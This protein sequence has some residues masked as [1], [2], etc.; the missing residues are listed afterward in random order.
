MSRY[1]WAAEEIATLLRLK[2]EG[3][4]N[5]EIGERLSVTD[6]AVK[7]KL[8][9]MRHAPPKPSDTFWTPERLSNLRVGVENR[10]S[11][12]DIAALLGCT[13]NA[14]RGK[15]ERLGLCVPSLR[16][17]RN[18]IAYQLPGRPPFDAR[19]MEVWDSNPMYAQCD[20]DVNLVELEY[21]SARDTAAKVL[22]DEPETETEAP[23][24]GVPIWALRANHCRAILNDTMDTEALRYC[25]GQTVKGGPWCKTHHARYCTPIPARVKVVGRYR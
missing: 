25:G 18:T 21:R 23:P 1:F 15:M 13:R 6:Q 17:K 19:T 8:K 3:L 11:A 14:V 4:S 2:E 22:F 9:K 7:N 5:Q 20:H 16:Q 24:D 12:A 10:L